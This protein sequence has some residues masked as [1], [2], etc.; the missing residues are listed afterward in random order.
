MRDIVELEVQKDVEAQI[1]E[2]LDDGGA[3]R[4][5]QRHA[6]L[7]PARLAGEQPRQALGLGGVAVQ[8]DDDALGRGYVVEVG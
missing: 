1:L 3:L 7:E 4:V 5:V 6:H 8:G 2:R